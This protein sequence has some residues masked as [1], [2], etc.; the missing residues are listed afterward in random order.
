MALP[1]P[2][3]PAPSVHSLDS[4]ITPGTPSLLE[5]PGC[6]ARGPHR[7]PDTCKAPL[8]LFF[9][10]GPVLRKQHPP[11]SVSKANLEGLSLREVVPA[12]LDCVATHIWLCHRVCWLS[13][14][15]S[16]RGTQWRYQVY[17]S[18]A[19]PPGFLLGLV[20]ESVSCHFSCHH[21][22]ASAAIS[23]KPVCQVP[24]LS[25]SRPRV[26]VCDPVPVPAPGPLLGAPGH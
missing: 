6:L 4:L 5:S 12:R 3:D 22:L 25:C 21:P 2:G 8:H 16:L 19:S 17:H 18:W 23:C 1:S 20:L 26:S 9:L 24:G 7:H 15:N 13:A 14:L 10:L 11:N